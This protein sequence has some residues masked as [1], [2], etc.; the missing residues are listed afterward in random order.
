MREVKIQKNFENEGLCGY[1]EYMVKNCAKLR[2]F[3]RRL[4]EKEDI[5]YKRALAIYEDLY[6][7]AIKLGA[8]TNDNILEQIEVSIKIA[9]AVNGLAE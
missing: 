2:E 4:I 8:V 3:Y 1:N 9:K 7:E 5:P 6:N